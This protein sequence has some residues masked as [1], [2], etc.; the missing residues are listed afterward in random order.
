VMRGGA[1][2]WAGLAKFNGFPGHAVVPRLR[3]DSVRAAGKSQLGKLLEARKPHAFSYRRQGT[4]PGDQL[5]S[6]RSGI[7]GRSWLGGARTSSRAVASWLQRD[8]T[9]PPLRRVARALPA[10]ELL[11]ERALV[12][13]SQLAS[14]E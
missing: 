8:T 1:T 4:A 2:C 7:L 3:L 9:S 12:V 14:E 11:N 10:D 6:S 13:I 5:G